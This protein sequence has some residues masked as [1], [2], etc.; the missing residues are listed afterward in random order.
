MKITIYSTPTCPHCVL[1]KDYLKQNNIDFQE[2]DLSQDEKAA[3]EIV[4]KT[5]QMGV[6]IIVVETD[7]GK[8]E[9]ILGFNR[10]LVNKIILNK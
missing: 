9:V 6:P 5:G 2:I 4:E 3:A 8:E 1:V 10:E 7:D